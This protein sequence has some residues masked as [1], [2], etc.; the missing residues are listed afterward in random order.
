[1]NKNCSVIYELSVDKN[2]FDFNSN[3]ETALDNA[4][5]ELQTINDKITEKLDSL[6][7]L[8]PECDKLDYALAASSGALCGIID[9]FLVGKPNQSP[10]GNITDKWFKERTKDFAKFCGWKDNGNVSSAIHFLEKRFRIPYDQTGLGET[11]RE[12]FELTPKNHHFKSLA[13]N[14]S[15]LG[16]FFSILNQF[17]NTSSFVTQGELITLQQADNRFE[18]RGNNIPSKLFCGFLNWLGHLVSDMSGSSNAQSR[19]MG[20]P[21][22]LWTWTNDII[23]IKRTF[24]IPVNEF[25]KYFN[26]LALKIFSQG[27]DMRFQTAQLIPVFINEML[28]R[29]IYAIR[30]MFKYF[31]NTAPENRSFKELWR[32]V[33]PFSNATVKRML[34]VAHGTFCMVDAGDAVIRGFV[35]GAGTFNV[36]EFVL[37]LNLPGLG[38]FAIS[39][40]GEATRGF[41]KRHIEADVHSLERKKQ[42]VEFYIDGLNQLAVM[43]DDKMLLNFVDDFKSSNMYKIGFEKTITLATKRKVPEDKILK[44]KKDIDNYFG[45]TV[46]LPKT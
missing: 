41:E 19:G 27:Y 30:R 33:E 24:N 38:R 43:Y 25:D 40:Y 36:V 13:H 4:N 29:S 31:A 1:M 26:E 32:N 7:K 45:L 14:P 44:T 42:I 34:T 16:L 3:I 15:L 18:L 8:T 11:G 17:T 35:K 21:S 12:I 5:M 22:P 6:K 23:A 10:L 37:R 20:L 2:G 39:L 9:V 28:V 46:K